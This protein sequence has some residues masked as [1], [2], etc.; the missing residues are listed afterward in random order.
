PVMPNDR[1]LA[2]GNVQVARL[3]LNHRGQQFVDQ[4]GSRSHESSWPP[5]ESGR[6]DDVN[7]KGKLSVINY[8]A[9]DRTIN[10]AAALRR[11]KL[12]ELNSSLERRDRRRPA[13]RRR[14]SRII[15]PT[16][17]PPIAF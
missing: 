14:C 15:R 12:G 3:E 6:H 13:H 7:K 17:A 5:F 11:K 9:A 2:H 4:N 10:R 8:S 1:R 16:A